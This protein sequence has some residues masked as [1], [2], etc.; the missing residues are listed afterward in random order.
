MFILMNAVT[1][2]SATFEP[3]GD[4]VR[5]VERIG[6]E[7]DEPADLPI[8]VARKLWVI[9]VE[10]GFRRD[11]TAEQLAEQLYDEYCEAE[12]RSEQYAEAYSEARMFG[13]DHA[14]AAFCANRHIRGEAY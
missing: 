8:D 7:R 14:D 13:Y 4:R 11:R 12:S 9:M 6:G 1:G 3:L 5:I 10:D 2:D